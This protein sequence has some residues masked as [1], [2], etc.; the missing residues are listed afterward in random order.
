MHSKDIIGSESIGNDRPHA[1]ERVNRLG[2]R[3]IPHRRE[4]EKVVDAEE[5]RPGDGANLPA[6]PVRQRVQG[7][8]TRQEQPAISSQSGDLGIE[9][10]FVDT[11]AKASN[12]QDSEGDH[13]PPQRV[14]I[15][16]GP[17]LSNPLVT[18]GYPLVKPS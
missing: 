9:G 8:V 18:P 6:P 14:H 2:S 16:T 5:N 7:R 10:R 11:E 15:E 13:D 3:L 17:Y 12:D 1:H 4:A